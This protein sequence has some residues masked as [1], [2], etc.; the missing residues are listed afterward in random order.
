MSKV[1]EKQQ[2]RRSEIIEAVIPLIASVPFDALSVNEI[3][4]A[5]GISVGSF[6]HY[7]EKKSD[8]LVGLLGLIDDY[9][10]SEVYPRLGEGS[11]K[12]KLLRF[13]LEWARYVEAHGIER[14]RLIS[15]VAPANTDLGGQKR[16]SLV[17]LENLMSEGQSE[18]CIS[19]EQ[20]PDELAE[21]YL[22]A[23]RAVT[24]DWSRQGGS[25]SIVEKMKVFISIWLNG[26][27]PTK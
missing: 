3:C 8:M 27:A 13:A 9:L 14:S 24:T 4:L 20:S 18:G 1:Q 23:L 7:F 17:Y 19:A 2:R 11:A 5:A 15:S 21:L 10:E 25:Y 16:S 22:L 12:D 26:I 6:Y